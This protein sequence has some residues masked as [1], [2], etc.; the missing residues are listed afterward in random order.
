MS[1]NTQRDPWFGCELWLG[2]VN[3]NGYPTLWE[4]G[5]PRQ[6]YYVALE[7]A[8]IVVPPEREPDH[9]C[10]RRLCVF[11]PHLQLITRNEN[12][13]RKFWA[14]RSQIERCAAG[15]EL[16]IHGRRTP[17]AGMVCRICSGVWTPQ[18]EPELE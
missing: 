1:W 16:R 15:H 9:L 6:A 17:E 14:H 13:R 7:R 18:S 5:R 8:G 10:R 3:S 12:Q 4:H 11:V 2:S